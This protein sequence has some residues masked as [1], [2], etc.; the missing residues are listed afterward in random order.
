LTRQQAHASIY[1]VTGI[2]FSR[3][4]SSPEPRWRTVGELVGDAAGR[5][6]GR[7]FLRFPAG[8]MTFAEA[9]ARSNRLA[10]LLIA[11]GVR[12][13]DR[14][15]I[16][17]GNVADWPVSWFA[18]LKASAI[19][20]PVNARYRESDLAYVLADSGAVLVLTAAEQAGLVRAVAAR[21]DAVREVRTLAELG[22]ELAEAPAAD[23]AVA[24]GQSG[25]ASFQY[26][27]GTTGFPKACLLSHGYWL[28]TGW[29]TAIEAEL[30]SG[31]VMLMAQAFSYM[32][33][34]WASLMCL[35]GGRPLVVLPR[36][37]ASGFWDSVREHGV[38][39]T[40][41]LG[42]MPALLYQRPPSALDRQS[43]MRLVLCS[44]IIPQLHRRFED[45]WGAPWRELYGSTES[46]LDLAVP[47]AA[48]ETVGTGAMGRP[49]PGKEVR[50]ADA[51]GRTLP[52]GETGQIVIRG[53]PM[54][55][56]YW[57]HPE[58][59]ERAFRG[60][61]YH[62]GDLGYRDAAGWIHHAG[63]LKDMIRRGGE[64]IAAA[65]VE[66]V[67][68]LHP[69]VAAAAL[70]PV[71]DQ[72]FGELP[73][74]FIQLRA[75]HE[76]STQT[77]ASLAEHVRARLARFKVPAYLEFVASFPMTP[78]ARIEKRKL[79]EP[80]RDQRAGAFDVAAGDWIGQE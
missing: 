4:G 17:M 30:R 23:L 41:L 2:L 18:V 57:N 73:K 11:H 71:P 20:V 31:D 64:N 53:E 8:P 32:D 56:G 28:R 55:R 42:A 50:I 62:S 45:R 19:A 68:A 13:G 54:M 77:A 16:M 9:H 6:A 38:T 40:Y 7:E 27:S 37:S 52:D 1:Q 67:L 29:L 47:P 58:A 79:T 61:W 75:G 35:M 51:D 76:A 48:A 74:A 26:T 44:G 5:F 66:N 70:V 10:H 63:R 21:A 59:T 39:L 72:L 60:G 65:E 78:S 43:E 3:A 69:A 80:G 14:V 12:P 25:I 36:F 46:G 33:P 24:P 34:Q 22:A 15:A 49:P